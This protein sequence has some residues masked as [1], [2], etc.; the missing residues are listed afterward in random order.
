MTCSRQD[1]MEEKRMKTKK[2]NRFLTFCFSMMPGAA[3]MY[4]GFMRTGT[5]LMLLFLGMIMV[6]S[7]LGLEGLTILDVVVW[8][9]GFFHANHLASL[10]DEEFAKVEDNDIFGMELFRKGKKKLQGNF[11]GIAIL[12][13]ILGVWL[14]WRTGVD[15]LWSYRVLPEYVYELL[16]TISD[17]VPRLAASVLIIVLGVHMIRGRKEELYRGEDLKNGEQEAP[18]QSGIQENPDREGEI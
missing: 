9:Y 11:R 18:D 12:L 10:S 14:L 1:E 3:E 2:K 8:A 4:M 15:M 16:F 6:P 17:Y 13:I 7:F 5:E